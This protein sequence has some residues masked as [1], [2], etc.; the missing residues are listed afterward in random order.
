MRFL[1]V[2]AVGARKGVP[3]LLDAWQRLAYAATNAELWIVGPCGARERALLPDAPGL[4]FLGQAPREK[5][6]EI[7]ASCD[8]FCLPSLSEGFALVL[9]EALAAGLPIV[10]TPNTGAEQVVNRR[11]LGTIVAAGDA[12]ALAGAIEQWRQ[13]PPDRQEVRHAAAELRD[14]FSWT[15]YGNRWAEILSGAA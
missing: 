4:R 2:G 9:L 11:A 8:V 6:P 1:F 13:A 7:F 14:I 15:A 3:V 10:A 12:D 5:I